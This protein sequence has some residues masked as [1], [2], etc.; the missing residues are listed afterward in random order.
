MYI[1]AHV[2]AAC[3]CIVNTSSQGRNNKASDSPLSYPLCLSLVQITTSFQYPRAEGDDVTLCTPTR[4]RAHTHTHTHT[5]TLLST[6]I[7]F[8]FYWT[9]LLSGKIE[10]RHGHISAV[11]SRSS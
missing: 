10:M 6:E 4:M 8:L 9:I 3:V 5:Q 7:R 1:A 11:C 2:Q